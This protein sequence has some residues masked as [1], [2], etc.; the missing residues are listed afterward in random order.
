MRCVAVRRQRGEMALIR[1]G[2]ERLQEAVRLL[3]EAGDEGVAPI[4]LW[5]QVVAKYP[6]TEAEAERTPSGRRNRAESHFRW[7]SDGL[8]KAGWITK[9]GRVWRATDA[10]RAALDEFPDAAQFQAGFR[11]E[12]TTWRKIHAQE[13]S[14]LSSRIVPQ[15]EDQER[16]IAA[17]RVFIER[18]LVQGESVFAPGRSL[19]TQTV[20]TE[21]VEC[22][23]NS[24]G[25]EG[26]GFLGKV[27][28][29]LAGA[30]DDAKLLMAELVTLQFLPAS[31]DAIG[32][33]SKKERVERV[34]ALMDH[35]VEIPGEILE[36]F[37][38]G[39]FNPGTR[40][41]SALGA[42]MTI[43]VNFVAA[44]ATLDD[45]KRSEI[46]ED[47]WEARRFVTE[48]VQGERFPSQRYSLLYMLHPETFVSIVSDAHKSAIRDAFLGEIRESSGDIDRDLLAITLALQIKS[49]SPALY[50]REPLHSK[51]KAQPRLLQPSEEALDEER[52]AESSPAVVRLPIATS[53]LAR[54]L[55]FDTAWLDST[56]RVLERRRQIILHGPPGTG[57]TY[58][59]RALARHL[60]GDAEPLIVQFHPSYSYEDFVEGYRPEVGAGGAL[61]YVLR[62]GPFRRIAREARLNK[63]RIFVLVID[64]IN[65]GN[66]AK[67]FGELYFLLEYRDESIGLLYG[68]EADFSMPSNVFIIGTMNTSD[69]SIA[70]LDA[71]M[72][73]R[74][75][76]QEL[77]PDDPPTYGVLRSWLRSNG[78]NDEAADLLERLNARISE[79]GARVG[80]SYLMP[81]DHDLSE[82]RLTDIWEHEIIPLLD[83]HHY[84]E[85]LDVRARY[86]LAALRRAARPAVDADDQPSADVQPE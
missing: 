11:R 19:W 72:R 38:A 54:T 78:L 21:L 26:D 3:L 6:L 31:T 76:F 80:P 79:R 24:D 81:R 70:L 42:A 49:N 71:A 32:A 74:F 83:E 33:K 40:M 25:T 62:E 61:T 34:L 30:S 68:S 4:V 47:P 77:H 23:V 56:I 2:G 63:D 64:E 52:A 5:E 73:R 44:W 10:G 28:V 27:A 53:E 18:G 48:D 36:A 60:T 55:H 51:W 39:S 15:D 20:S 1:Y 75:G 37:S 66:L 41:S 86:G 58:V 13:S 50:Y 65:R 85:N 8:G 22:F 67:I 12:S 17:A 29:Q 46:L 59:A 16:V 35:P 69:R 57:K 84:G 43:L 7:S 9:D 82:E 45:D 14:M